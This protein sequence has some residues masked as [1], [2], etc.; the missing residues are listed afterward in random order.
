MNSVT[1][2]IAGLPLPR[3]LVAVIQAGKWCPPT[4]PQ[5]YIDTFGELPDCPLF[6]DLDEMSR[7]N[8]SWQNS[9]VEEEFGY[10]VEGRSVGIDPARSVLIGDLCP[11]M[12]IALDF[13]NSENSPSVLYRT[14]R[15]II[16]WVRIAD[17]VGGLLERLKIIPESY[18]KLATESY[19]ACFRAYRQN[20][21]SCTWI[22]TIASR[23][24][25]TLA[26]LI[27]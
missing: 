13:R 12:P 7:Q 16:V 20:P 26:R 11:D 21:G 3:E 5:V 24:V 4:D 10:P 18:G 9:S 6:Y 1:H 17:S 2:W 15:G 8:G 19:P 25:R 14:Q 23:V 27:R 22:T